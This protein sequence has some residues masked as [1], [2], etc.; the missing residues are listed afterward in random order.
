MSQNLPSTESSSPPGHQDQSVRL[1]ASA[2]VD[3]VGGTITCAA[4]GSTN[5]EP[6]CHP[7]EFCQA[8]CNDCNKPLNADGSVWV[9]KQEP[10]LEQF[11]R[12][13]ENKAHA[14]HAEYF[15]GP[16]GETLSQEIERCRPITALLS[17]T[18]I[19]TELLMQFKLEQGA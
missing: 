16:Q 19:A 4:C 18:R 5:T 7:A 3:Q 2:Q 17:R 9:E 13:L 12:W 15:N 1:A 11:Q 10:T 8:I 6:C 14:A